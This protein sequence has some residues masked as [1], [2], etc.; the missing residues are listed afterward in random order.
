MN[1]FGEVYDFP[2]KFGHFA[3][4]LLGSNPGEVFALAVME[5]LPQAS[6]LAQDLLIFDQGKDPQPG[7][8]CIAPFGERLFLIQIASKTFDRDIHSFE[9]AQQY[10]IPE[11]LTN[12]EHGQRLN[13]YPLAYNEESHELFIEIAEEQDWSIVAIP[14][15]FV[16]ATAL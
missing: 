11:E 10:P 4:L 12:P 8:I 15:D 5:D 6:L 14:P 2:E 16:V 1:K 9:M 3:T 13:W 7:D